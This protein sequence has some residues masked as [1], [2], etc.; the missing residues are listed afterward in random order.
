M[1]DRSDRLQTVLEDARLDVIAVV[2]MA[3]VF[4]YTG[5]LIFQALKLASFTTGGG[6]FATPHTTWAKLAVLAQTGGGVLIF[7][8][9]IAIA[10]A[11]FFDTP[12]ARLALRLALIGGAWSAI[13]GAIGVAVA[14]HLDTNSVIVSPERTRQVLQALQAG[15]IGGLGLVVAIVAWR[16]RA[17]PHAVPSSSAAPQLAELS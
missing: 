8:S 9:I 2:W 10:M 17:R 3:L 16:M 5:A 7:G 15:A 6:P 4:V 11:A 13:A 14:F 12:A 1:N